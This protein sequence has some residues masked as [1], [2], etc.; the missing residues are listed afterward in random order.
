MGGW[1]LP[2]L[3]FLDTL[4]IHLL[5]LQSSELALPSLEVNSSVS[6]PSHWLVLK[7]PLWFPGPEWILNPEQCLNNYLRSLKE[8]ALFPKSQEN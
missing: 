2:S 6:N 5:L 1:A 4:P 3:S 8:D 7:F